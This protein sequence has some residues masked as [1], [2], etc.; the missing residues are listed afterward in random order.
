MDSETKKRLEQLKEDNKIKIA[1]KQLIDGLDTFY[2]IDISG[3][4]FVDYQISK[5]IHS[6]VY[7]IIKKDDIKTDKFHFEDNVIDEKLE[8]LFNIFQPFE[9][10]GVLIFPKAFGFYFRSSNYLYLNFPIAI[11]STIKGFK[12]S[13]V[14]LIHDI[15]D[16]LIVVEQNAKYGFVINIDEYQDI[17]IEF[18]G[19]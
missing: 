6:L 12:N 1:K 13:I 11:I 5:K 14:K 4:P 2:A 9:N 7:K 8:H 17:S 15:Q 10:A 3:L 19:I 18:W 16:D